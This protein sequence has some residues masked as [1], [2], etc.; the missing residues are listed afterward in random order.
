MHG[1][2]MVPARTVEQRR[3]ALKWANEIRSARAAW[4]KDVKAGRRDPMPFLIEPPSEFETM[5]IYAAL[6]AMPK[7]GRTKA[8]TILRITRVSPAK[9]LGGMTARQ[10]AEV[11]SMVPR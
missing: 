11:V 2:T 7:I 10:R 3:A 5:K 1:S 4:K 9:T 8:Q 6:L